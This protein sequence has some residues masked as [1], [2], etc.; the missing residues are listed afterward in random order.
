MRKIIGMQCANC[1]VS[2]QNMLL[3]RKLNSKFEPELFKENSYHWKQR[4]ENYFS[5]WNANNYSIFLFG[6]TSVVL[7]VNLFFDFAICTIWLKN[8]QKRLYFAFYNSRFHTFLTSTT[9]LNY[10]LILI[11]STQ[12]SILFLKITQFLF[13]SF[14]SGESS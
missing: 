7:A 14:S 1:K 8:S 5:M 13:D 2:Y 6:S 9:H 12:H 3:N 10:L 4:H 11:S